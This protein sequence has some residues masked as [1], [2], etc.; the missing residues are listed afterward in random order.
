MFIG[1]LLTDQQYIYLVFHEGLV[2]AET[3]Y[4]SL[5]ST[6]Q[7]L[8]SPHC[9]T[10]E[11]VLIVEDEPT[12]AEIYGGWLSEA[13]N[14]TIETDGESALTHIDDEIDV[15]LLDRRMPGLSGDAVLSEI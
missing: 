12:L 1:C 2:V 8:V 6:E 14:V 5:P 10:F 3:S 4:S 13:Y 7:T 11:T 9:M 15:V